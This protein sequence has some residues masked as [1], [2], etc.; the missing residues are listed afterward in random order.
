VEDKQGEEEIYL[1][2][3]KDVNTYVKNDWS[4]MICANTHRHTGKNDYVLTDGETHRKLVKD[5]RTLLEADEH[6]TIKGSRLATVEGT[7]QL[8]V[9]ALHL[10][11]GREIVIESGSQIVLKVGDTFIKL[12]GSG[13]V[14]QG[15]TI[16]QNC[17]K[18][19]PASPGQKDRLL[20]DPPKGADKGSKPNGGEMAK[21]MP[22]KKGTEASGGGEGGD[23]AQTPVVGMGGKPDTAFPK[24]FQ[25]D[26]VSAPPSRAYTDKELANDPEVQKQMQV[27]LKNALAKDKE[28][29]G[30]IYEKEDGSLGVQHWDIDDQCT[31]TNIYSPYPDKPDRTVGWFHTHQD[32]TKP[33][34][35]SASPGDVYMEKVHFKVPGLI[36]TNIDHPDYPHG[37][38]PNQISF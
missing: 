3:E 20:P 34:D 37:I 26:N 16:W 6:Q 17:G 25:T 8:K 18:S 9:G 12:T 31:S 1:R 2:G 28:Q 33:L 15:P 35:A 5:R 19:V 29:G 36:Q 24:I 10:Q 4:D 22:S 23:S 13:I 38:I 27:S 32:T 11:S 30:W 21:P 14:E 7:E